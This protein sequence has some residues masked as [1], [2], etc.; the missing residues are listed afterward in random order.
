MV[1]AVLVEREGD[2]RGDDVGGAGGGGVG[3]W[4]IGGDAGKAHYDAVGEAEG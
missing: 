2:A 3:Y 1:H 4:V